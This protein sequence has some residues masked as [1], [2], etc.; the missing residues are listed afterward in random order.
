MINIKDFKASVQKYDLER[1]NLFSV[2]FP[3][4]KGFNGTGISSTIDNGGLVTLF[5]KSAV[6][7]GINLSLVD[8]TRYGIGPNVKMP[9]RG[10][11]NDVTMTFL[12]DAAGRCHTFFMNWL[13]LIYLQWG[14]IINISPGN[15]DT[16][17][18]NYKKNYEVDATV[19]MYS[20]EPGKTGGARILQTIASAA[21]SAAGIPFVGSLL[22]SR[23]GPEHKLQVSR[24][25]T[26]YKM[27]PTNVSDISLSS[28]SVDS[29]TEFSVGFTYQTYNTKITF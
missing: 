26:F 15:N 5:C 27:F 2:D 10:N 16:Y 9:V 17:L 6:L 25:F 1:P 12:N 21:S 28:S 23:P 29:V 8:N 7:P 19:S 20:G 11:L 22:G 13:D 18:L 14:P 24:E 4:P 3:I